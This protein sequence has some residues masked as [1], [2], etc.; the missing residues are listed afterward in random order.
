MGLFPERKKR[1][2]SLGLGR[3]N[4]CLECLI[5]VGCFQAVL[6]EE[7]YQ[8]ESLKIKQLKT[9][10]VLGQT[11]TNLRD[12]EKVKEPK[13]ARELRGSRP[14]SCCGFKIFLIPLTRTSA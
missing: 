5:I 7:L 12:Q 9:P 3:L 6:S 2:L 13:V 1:G 10:E 11:E 4:L 8:V 14:K